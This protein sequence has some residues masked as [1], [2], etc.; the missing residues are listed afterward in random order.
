M[1]NPIPNYKNVEL[2]KTDFSQFSHPTLRNDFIA[3]LENAIMFMNFDSLNMWHNESKKPINL[4]TFDGA[5]LVDYSLNHSES[6][7]FTFSPFGEFQVMPEMFPDLNLKFMNLSS[8]VINMFKYKFLSIEERRHLE[9]FKHIFSER[10]AFLDYSKNRWFT[11]EMGYGIN[12]ISNLDGLKAYL[13]IPTS[14][15]DGH[16]M[17]K[18]DINKF[19]IENS[20]SSDSAYIQT[21]KNFNMALNL[22]MTYYYEWSCYI[23]ENEKS[24][25]IRIPIHPSS[26]K[27]VFSM[28]D[29]TDKKKA[30]LNFVRDHY[31]TITDINGKERDILI[32]KHFRGELKFNWRGLEVHITPSEYD[33]NRI[34]TTKVFKKF[35]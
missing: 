34:K 10:V 21:V 12:S 14:L 16:F 4:K 1:D 32:N 2:Q 20:K 29:V 3:K 8:E 25:G 26:S 5:W 18:S 6:D 15:S 33:L 19:I 35:Y 30:I 28:R 31:R 23:K 13:P 17:K 11:N 24:F 7:D 22:K 9:K 27:E